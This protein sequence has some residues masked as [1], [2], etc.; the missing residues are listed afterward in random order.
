[1]TRVLARIPCPGA[2]GVRAV[3]I[4]KQAK[5]DGYTLVCVG[6]SA[7]T[8]SPHM[9]NT[10]YGPGDFAHL[11]VLYINPAGVVV[12]SDS[13]FKKFQDLIEYARK[14][15]GQLTIGIPG[16]GTSSHL[17][18][19]RFANRE[20]IK[21]EFVPFSGSPPLTTAILG[22]HVMSA[23]YIPFAFAPHVRAGTLR[24]LLVYAHERLKGLPEVPTSDELGF[25]P[26]VTNM[27]ASFGSIAAPK[28]LPK[29]I[30][31]RLITAFSEG[32]KSTEYRNLASQSFMTLPAPPLVGEDLDKFYQTQYELGGETIR[33]LGLQKK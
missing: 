19:T 27:F 2:A 12:R 24:A 16:Y 21:F 23:S 29:T 4:L 7:F 22:G 8:K 30:K 1:M 18:L 26:E 32:V 28:G 15:P 14:N 9:V 11:I 10:S 3:E 5:P 25:S 31:D 33:E 6:D 13:P 20:K 17:G